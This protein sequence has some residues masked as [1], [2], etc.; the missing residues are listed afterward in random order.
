MNIA[1]CIAAIR[2]HGIIIII[3]SPLLVNAPLVDQWTNDATQQKNRAT[4]LMRFFIH[5]RLGPRSLSLESNFSL[6]NHFFHHHQL[7]HHLLLVHNPG[8]QAPPSFTCLPISV[9][10]L[11]VFFARLT[12]SSLLHSPKPIFEGPTKS[13]H[14]AGL[15]TLLSF[16]SWGRGQAGEGRNLHN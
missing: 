1:F 15:M 12:F 4:I 2:T 10:C 5:S 16:T 14:L 13:I 8:R 6:P 3:I 7:I 11:P 9:H